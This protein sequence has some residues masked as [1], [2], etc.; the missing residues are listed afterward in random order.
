[1]YF[2]DNEGTKMKTIYLTSL[3]R[4]LCFNTPAVLAFL[5]YP[6]KD[7]VMCLLFF[8]GFFF[9]FS[10]YCCVCVVINHWQ[11]PNNFLIYIPHIHLNI[12]NYISLLGQ[13][14]SVLYRYSLLL[15]LLYLFIK[16]K[17]QNIFGF[18]E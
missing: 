3:S 10:F 18:R 2:G 9:S 8:W 15:L 5:M 4:L 1:M 12:Y 17:S 14:R 13:S 16:Q 11:H 7:T 6:L